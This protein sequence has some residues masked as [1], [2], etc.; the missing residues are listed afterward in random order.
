L[1][2][3]VKLEEAGHRLHGANPLVYGDVDRL[4]SE[5]VRGD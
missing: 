5:F 4:G 3:A 2:V 1:G